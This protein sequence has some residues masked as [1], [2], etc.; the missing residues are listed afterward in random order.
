MEYNG[1]LQES[2]LED[3][4]IYKSFNSANM[5]IEKLVKY[6]KTGVS[7]DS[8][9]FEEQYMQIKKVAISP[10]SLK[11]LQ[12]FDNGD[13]EL[14]YSRE[15]KI[16]ASLPFII[17]KNNNGRIVATIFIASFGV[18]DKNNTLS[19]PV[20]QLYALMESAYVALQMQVN[21]MKLQ[22]NVALMRICSD[23]Y[24][25]MM[26]RILT[27][28]YA[29]TT[30]KTLYDKAVYVITRFF[31]EKIWEYPN[32][33]LIE[34]YAQ[35]NLKFI[36]QLDLD[37]VKTGYDAAQIKDIN[38]M[39][40]YLK[41]LSPRLSDLNTRYFIEQFINTFH[42]SSIM[43]LDYL[44]YVFFVIINVILGSF[45]ISQ[46]ALNDLIKNVKNINHF[47]SELAKTI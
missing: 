23:V 25:A 28:G 39:I 30:D 13:I 9:Y 3:S 26:I 12:A 22:R 32:A 36:E 11:V 37:L 19:I 14:L 41:T 2:T 1:F 47:Y 17:R 6:L 40:Q 38:D 29:I 35:I 24:V 45:L 42:G 15:T 7:L 27:K 34:S 18:I 33:S 43:S 10:L 8:S 20:K 5:L 4:Y 16:G 46:T 31:L 21:P 44:P